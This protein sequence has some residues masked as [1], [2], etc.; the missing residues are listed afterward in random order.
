MPHPSVALKARI[1]SEG[2]N[3]T[4]RALRSYGPPFLIKRR[5]YGNQDPL[6][7]TRRA[8]PQEI[9]LGKQRGLVVSVDINP[10]SG[11]V[12]DAESSD[13]FFVVTDR[14]PRWEISFPRQPTFYDEKIDSGRYAS[15]IITLYGGGSLGVFAFGRCDLVDRGEACQYC[16]IEPNRYRDD[17]YPVLV[18]PGDLELAL[19][20][21]LNDKS[22]PAQQVMLNGGNFSHPDRGFKYYLRL[23]EAARVAID[24]SHREV[25]LHLIVFPPRDLALL[26]DL[27]P[28]GVS[29]AMNLEV[30][31][32]ALFRKYCP[33]KH[34][35][36][37]QDH[38]LRAL[39]VAAE[40]LGP[41]R[42]FSILVGGL[43]DLETLA[44]GM[45]RLAKKGV[46]PVINVFH[47]DPETPLATH[48]RPSPQSILE[49][50]SALQSVY[51]EHGFSP[52]Y[53]GCGRHSLDDEAAAGL[54]D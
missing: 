6:E 1:L 34:E 23:C 50:G 24:A 16:S 21:A 29:V 47:P 46:T 32:S 37:G 5:A 25:E 13:L 19:R 42:V 35:V 12:L 26:A 49:M 15:Q 31:D 30:F 2:V 48:R 22:H 28:L 53:K 33:G 44:E 40:A 36:A 38:I 54:F 8:I 52:F 11:V 20:V 41:G 4:E 45:E 7:Y 18:T 10:L 39:E 3:I 9:F 14:G 43:E 27:A 51:E 17:S